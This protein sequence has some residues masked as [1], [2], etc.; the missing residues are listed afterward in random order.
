M[1]DDYR[2]TNVPDWILKLFSHVLDPGASIIRKRKI[3]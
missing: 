3:N 1:I 2:W